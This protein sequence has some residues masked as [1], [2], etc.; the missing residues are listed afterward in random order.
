MELTIARAK[1]AYEETKRLLD[2]HRQERMR[3]AQEIAAKAAEELLPFEVKAGTP[4]AIDPEGKLPHV[5]LELGT[6][7][8]WYVK[9]THGTYR[10]HHE[11]E[12]QRVT[13]LDNFV[14]VFPTFLWAYG[15]ARMKELQELRAENEM[16]R[17]MMNP[18]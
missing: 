3:L 12:Q 18:A 2:E 9:Y 8:H 15:S 11:H 13:N 10:L 5:G 16:L 6:D 1:A 14:K 4:S 7:K 17:K